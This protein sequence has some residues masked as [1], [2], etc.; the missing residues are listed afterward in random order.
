VIL[1]DQETRKE[2][3]KGTATVGERGWPCPNEGGCFYKR[4]SD[5]SQTLFLSKKDLRRPSTSHSSTPTAAVAV[6]MSSSDGY[7]RRWV[8]ERSFA[9]FT[10]QRQLSKN[11]E[12]RCRTSKATPPVVQRARC[13]SVPLA[14]LASVL[15]PA[16]VR[17]H[18]PPPFLRSSLLHA[19]DPGRDHHG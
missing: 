12:R 13:Q 7:R 4:A 17:R 5:T 10:G 19:T 11:L 2:Q 1:R 15:P 9:W 18:L 3:S 8:V 6:N 14:K 16:L